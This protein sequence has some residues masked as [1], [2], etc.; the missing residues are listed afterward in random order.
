MP[1]A[2]AAPDSYRDIF[3]SFFEAKENRL[4]T[5]PLPQSHLH[6]NNFKFQMVAEKA[7]KVIVILRQAQ[8]DVRL[9][10]TSGSG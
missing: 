1:P 7:F 2:D 6:L 3:R 5:A 9:R 10:M 8:D 4:N